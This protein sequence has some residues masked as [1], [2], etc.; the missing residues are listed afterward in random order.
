MFPLIPPS[1]LIATCKNR[2]LRKDDT[3]F[4]EFINIAVSSGYCLDSLNVLISGNECYTTEIY[5]MRLRF[6]ITLRLVG[7]AV[8]PFL[9]LITGCLILSVIPA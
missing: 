4:R 1:L 6:H 3:L 9:A 2:R 8:F 7:T 5:S